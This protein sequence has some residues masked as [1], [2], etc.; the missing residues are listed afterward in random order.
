MNLE[1][2]RKIA[3]LLE[4]CEILRKAITVARMNDA[5]RRLEARVP[6]RD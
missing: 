6:A 3:E 5:Q 2:D 1:N 4:R